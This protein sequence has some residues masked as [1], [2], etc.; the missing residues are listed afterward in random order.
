[1]QVDYTRW[2]FIVHDSFMLQKLYL[3]ITHTKS[4]L[5]GWIS[6]TYV[7]DY[8][9]MFLAQL[10]HKIVLLVR[11][12]SQ[13]HIKSSQVSKLKVPDLPQQVARYGFA[14]T[15]DGSVCTKDG[16]FDEVW[17]I[18]IGHPKMDLLT[19]DIKD[20]RFCRIVLIASIFND[21]TTGHKTYVL[22]STCVPPRY[23]KGSSLKDDEDP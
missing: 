23:L 2:L 16:Q 4:V 1:M 9:N 12:R 14:D 10:L 11:T 6:I 3:S 18:M 8:I 20:D 19:A 17:I 13:N 5:Y 7:A 22:V 15:Q 21:A